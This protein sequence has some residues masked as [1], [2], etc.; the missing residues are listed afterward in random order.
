[1]PD[2]R[3]YLTPAGLGGGCARKRAPS[4]G[5]GPRVNPAPATEARCDLSEALDTFEPHPPWIKWG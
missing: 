4:C 1:M 5:V 2:A 3:R